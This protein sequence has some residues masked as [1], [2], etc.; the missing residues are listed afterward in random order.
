ME[1]VSRDD[2]VFMGDPRLLIVCGNEKKQRR[3][4]ET[5]PPYGYIEL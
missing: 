1:N 3:T 2:T 4:S 5:G